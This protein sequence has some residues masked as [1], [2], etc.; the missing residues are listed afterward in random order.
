MTKDIRRYE[1]VEDTSPEEASKMQQQMRIEEAQ[2]LRRAKKA[3][4][5]DSASTDPA[6]PDA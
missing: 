6:S 3:E 5:F 2:R 1:L 4:G